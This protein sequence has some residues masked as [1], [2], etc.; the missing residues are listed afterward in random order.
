[1]GHPVMLSLV[2]GKNVE[3]SLSFFKSNFKMQ[4]Q[5]LTDSC[6]IRLSIFLPYTHLF[7]MKNEIW[8]RDLFADSY[9]N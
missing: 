8:G 1:M 6:L 3:S 2:F 5:V 9:H 7:F 4:I